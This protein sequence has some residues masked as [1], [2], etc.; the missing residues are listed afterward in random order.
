MFDAC[1]SLWTQFYQQTNIKA[2]VYVSKRVV[3]FGLPEGEE[4]ERRVWESVP[5]AKTKSLKYGKETLIWTRF[6]ACFV[7]HEENSWRR[8]RTPKKASI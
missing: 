3:N 2:S 4:R 7:D 5:W 1:P 8:A 6:C